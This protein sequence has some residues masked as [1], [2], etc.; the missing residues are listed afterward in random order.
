ML[1]EPGYLLGEERRRK[2]GL[3]SNNEL[4]NPVTNAKA[5]YSILNE[6][7]WH[8]WSVYTHG[9]YKKYYDAAKE[10]LQRL[11]KTPTTLKKKASISKP[12]ALNVAS[13]L[14]DQADYESDGYQIAIL[15]IRQI[16][17]K[18]VPMGGSGSV[19]FIDT[20]NSSN[21]FAPALIG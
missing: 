8:A 16:I 6:Q 1:D 10:A 13:G 15:P 5:A 12:S 9:I 17:Q 21:I 19:T 7:G 18:P 4:F 11:S 3:K 20:T 2:F 14:D